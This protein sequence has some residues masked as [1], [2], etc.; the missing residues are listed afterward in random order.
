MSSGRN[1][2]VDLSH[3][4]RQVIVISA[5]L[6]PASRVL[7]APPNSLGTFPSWDAACHEAFAKAHELGYG[8]RQVVL[9]EPLR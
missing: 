2:F 4:E 7:A 8:I 3:S 1:Y 6:G 5:P 9:E